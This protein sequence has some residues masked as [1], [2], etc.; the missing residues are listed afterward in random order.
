M[1]RHDIYQAKSYIG[2]GY[3]LIIASFIIGVFL[4]FETPV[5]GYVLLPLGV[6]LWFLNPWKTF[7]LIDLLIQVRAKEAQEIEVLSNKK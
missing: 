3:A 4:S 5:I 6:G 1:W 2:G 7:K